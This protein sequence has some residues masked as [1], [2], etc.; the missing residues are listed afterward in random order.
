MIESPGNVATPATALTVVD[1][2]SVA[3]LEFVMRE[4][5]TEPVS[6]VAMLP[7]ALRNSTLSGV[8]NEAPAT[9]SAG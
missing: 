1:P 5:E 7:V 9:M 6:D 8:A 4:S 2:D 3:P